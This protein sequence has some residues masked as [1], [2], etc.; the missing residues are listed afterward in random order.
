MSHPDIVRATQRQRLQA[1]ETARLVATARSRRSTIGTRSAR[2]APS[3][4]GP[5]SLALGAERLRRALAGRSL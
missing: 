3:P 4:H 5:L 2:R 1:A